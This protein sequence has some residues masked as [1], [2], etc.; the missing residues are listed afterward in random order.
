MQIRT[1]HGWF[2]ALLRDAPL[3]VLQS[4]GL[5]T[6]FELL[7][8]DTEAVARV[9]RRFHAA[10]ERDPRPRA[11]YEACVA[12]HG[13][14]NTLKALESA[15]SKRVEFAMADAHGVVDDSVRPFG[16][17]FPQFAG[18]APE[19]SLA[20]VS[21]PILQSLILRLVESGDIN[22][23]DK[24][25]GTVFGY[26]PPGTPLA[27]PRTVTGT[28]Q[29]DVPGLAADATGCTLADVRVKDLL[30]HGSGL[31]NFDDATTDDDT[32]NFDN[33]GGGAVTPQ[34]WI[35]QEC[36][37]QAAGQAPFFKP[38]GN[39][40]RYM[41]TEFQILAKLIEMKVGKPYQQYLAEILGLLPVDRIM[42]AHLRS[43]LDV[44]ANHVQSIPYELPLPYL[45][46]GDVIPVPPNADG[47]VCDDWADPAC[48]EH[49][50]M[51]SAS[52]AASPNRSA[53]LGDR[54]RRQP[55]WHFDHQQ[56]D[57]RRELQAGYKRFA[58]QAIQPRRLL[59]G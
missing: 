16:E 57:I 55:R 19:E 4:L 53:A 32:L 20:S 25:F 38:P 8:D 52:I 41:N 50:F 27:C 9:W 46:W 30:W 1:F 12:A 54:H 6:R 48:P 10:V 35:Q 28:C 24:P 23:N 13:R 2:A 59:P 58:R 40:A 17:R 18:L 47:W 7:E 44:D 15:L 37:S 11:D 43:Q 31:R 36:D 45:F 21:K 51:G 22:L 49:L 34:S 56:D 39:R 29:I 5:P 33:D 26:N 42:P 14:F 3:A